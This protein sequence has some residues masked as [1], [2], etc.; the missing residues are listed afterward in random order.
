M[1]FVTNRS[2]KFGKSR[3]R[4]SRDSPKKGI[5]FFSWIYTLSEFCGILGLPILGLHSITKCEFVGFVA[6][7]VALSTVVPSLQLPEYRTWQSKKRHYIVWSPTSQD[8]SFYVFIF[9]VSSEIFCE[10]RSPA[11]SSIGLLRVEH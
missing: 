5:L 4:V 7:N 10:Q 6:Q 1:L 11:E 9:L 2:W 8:S 3:K